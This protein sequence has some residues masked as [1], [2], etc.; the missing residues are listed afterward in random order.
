MPSES[1][2]PPFEVPKT[3]LWTFMLERKDKDFSDDKGTTVERSLAMFKDTH[4]P[5]LV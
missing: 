1:N 2:Y 4:R 3:D 5:K